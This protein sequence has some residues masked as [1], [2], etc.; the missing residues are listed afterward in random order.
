MNIEYHTKLFWRFHG[1]VFVDAG[2]IRT[3]RQYEEQSGG[4]S[5]LHEFYKQI[6]VTYRLR[7]RLNFNFFILRFDIGMRTISPAHETQR[8]HFAVFHPNLGRDLTFHLAMGMSFQLPYFPRE[9]C[10]NWFSVC[11]NQ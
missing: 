1:A 4:Q 9:R 11:T 5:K 3:L 7:L 2:S 8:E 6:A 10:M